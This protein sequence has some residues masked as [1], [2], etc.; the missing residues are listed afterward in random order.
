VAAACSGARLDRFVWFGVLA[1]RQWPGNAQ[2]L[3]FRGVIGRCTAV[4]VAVAPLE[5]AVAEGILLYDGFNGKQ[6]FA[7]LGEYLASDEYK[8]AAKVLAFAR[9][10]CIGKKRSRSVTLCYDFVV[11]FNVKKFLSFILCVLGVRSLCSGNRRRALCRQ[12]RGL[13]VRRGLRRGR[14]R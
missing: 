4:V 6:G 1:V 3:D 12:A 11:N 13:R 14:A 7:A 10:W 8:A 9:L 5:G 2:D